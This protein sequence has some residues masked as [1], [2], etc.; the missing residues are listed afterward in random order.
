[1]K[2]IQV[3]LVII[4][5]IFLHYL[6]DKSNR[7]NIHRYFL[8]KKIQVVDIEWRPFGPGWFGDK[9]WI[10]KVTYTKNNEIN[11]TYAKT[12]LFSR[13]YIYDLID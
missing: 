12:G 13:V 8:K 6:Y 1:M 10:Y 9:N 11:S 3:F 4:F 2:L 5:L 7:K